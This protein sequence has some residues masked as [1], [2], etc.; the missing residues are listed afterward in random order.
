MVAEG[1]RGVAVEGVEALRSG[2]IRLRQTIDGVTIERVSDR[3]GLSQGLLQ[4]QRSRMV[5][6]VVGA[7]AMTAPAVEL[8][9]VGGDLAAV[10][11]RIE[12]RDA[13]RRDGDRTA[14]EPIFD[15]GGRLR[16]DRLERD[17]PRVRASVVLR[18]RHLLLPRRDTGHHPMRRQA[19]AFDVE[20]L[21]VMPDADFRAEQRK[22]LGLGRAGE[23]TGGGR[24][25]LRDQGRDAGEG[26]DRGARVIMFGRIVGLQPGGRQADAEQEEGETHGVIWNS[27]RLCR[28]CA[29]HVRGQGSS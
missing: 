10:V 18:Q 24:A 13:V 23:A 7:A 17:A 15:A 4:V 3:Q 19:I 21:F 8:A 26:R 27:C 2:T 29:L 14:E 22:R 5:V 25:G 28:P 20:E 6:V 12:D 1:R 9:D 16:G 11:L